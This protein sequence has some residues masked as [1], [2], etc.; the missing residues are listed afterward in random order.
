MLAL[1]PLDKGIRAALA[2]DAALTLRNPFR[3]ARPL[4]LQSIMI[5]QPVDLLPD[6]R[7]SMCDG[8]PDMT[9]HEDKLVWSCRL[10]ERLQFGQFM[11]AVPSEQEFP[12]EAAV[13]VSAVAQSPVQILTD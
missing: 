6:G 11:R 13:P 5:I 8:C 1:A 10:D 7:Q 9:I 2:K 4:H 12:A 3:L